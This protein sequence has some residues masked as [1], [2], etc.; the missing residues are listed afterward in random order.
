MPAASFVRFFDNHGLL[1]AQPNL[2]WRVVAGG[3]ASYVAP[4]VRPFRERIRVACPVRRGAR[5]AQGVEIDSPAGREHFDHVVLAVHSDQALAMLADPSPL[6][7]KLLGAV[8]YQENEV[9]LHTD[10]SLM[11]RS[12]HAA[13]SWN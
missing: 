5:T 2:P 11:P 7:R 8:A 4:L 13:A 9:V 1:E 12:R 10:T 6:E 3:S